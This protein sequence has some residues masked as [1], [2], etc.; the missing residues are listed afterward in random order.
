MKYFYFFIFFLFVSCNNKAE[1]HLFTSEFGYPIELP[2][3]WAE[4][5]DEKNVN[6]FFNTSEWT[7]NLRITPLKVDRNESAEFLKK[8]LERPSG[9]VKPFKT[10]TGFEG[11]RYS[12]NGNKDEFMYY[13]F[14]IANEKM[15]IC[16]FTID[17]DKKDTKENQMELTI[18]TEIVS[19]IKLKST[20]P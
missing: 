16:S 15:F 8:E 20:S 2:E 3:N 18:L 11:L 12:E 5:D 13:W 19:S 10:K 4:Y 14:I 7:G 17:L 6:A 9:K 1:T